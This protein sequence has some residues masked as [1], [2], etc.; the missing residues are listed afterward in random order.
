MA[1]AYRFADSMLVM[2][3][4]NVTPDSFS[5]GGQF[6]DH[7]AAISHA[8]EL[9][10]QGAQIID[11]GGE[12][13]RP[14]AER[15]GVAEELRR[16]LPVVR[17]LARD[18]IRVSVDTMNA[19][20]AHATID[21]GAEFINDVSG[22]LADPDM[23]AVAAGSGAPYILSHW[24]GHSVDMNSR[25]HYD[26]VVVDVRTELLGRL[27]ALEAGGVERDRIILDPGLGFAKTADQNWEILARISELQSLGL[28][29]LVG[30]SRKRFIAALLPDGASMTE[31]DLPTAVV[32]ALLADAGL[33]GVRVHN[34]AA[35]TVALAARRRLG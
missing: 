18:G 26:D 5:D 24:R 7:D 13:T 4:L 27:E 1:D 35:T 33:W 17:A 12:S 30:A 34:V 6:L 28:P 20:T 21:A 14:G 15:I 9:V 3:I 29:V 25:A 31:R 2:G 22:G 32:S 11:V 10:G 23:V 19:E 8:R 16:I